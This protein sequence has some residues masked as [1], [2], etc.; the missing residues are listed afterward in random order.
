MSSTMT[1]T[2]VDIQK[3]IDLNYTS[4]P[5]ELVDGGNINSKVTVEDL[6]REIPAHC[7]KSTY[8]Q[9]L[10]YLFR[11]LMVSGSLM[12]AAYTFVSQIE[13][14]LLRHAAWATYGYVQGLA[15]TG[16]WVLG[17]ECGHTAFSPPERHFSSR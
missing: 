5:A 8:R 3:A 12:A 14:N 15:F 6:R 4:H 16:L 7:F 1:V 2:E 9:S 13:N 11:D 17:H 10:W